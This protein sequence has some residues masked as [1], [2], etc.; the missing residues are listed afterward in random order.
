LPIPS[1]AEVRWSDSDGQHAVKTKLEGVPRHLSDDWTLYFVIN[2]DATVQARAIKY[3]DKAAMA[4]LSKGLRPEGE[5]RLAFI[6]KTGRDLEAVYAY[7]GEQKV[8]GSVIL[9][10]R[11][12]LAYS[13]PLTLPIPPEVEL[14]WREGGEPHAAKVKLEGLVPKSFE[15]RIFFLI[16]ADGAVEVHPIKKGD[17]TGAFKLVK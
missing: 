3:D 14:R 11:A 10:T 16:K 9:P 1:E 5:Y 12:K 2:K 13:D 8:G 17:D 4:E 15:G 6:N 7:Y